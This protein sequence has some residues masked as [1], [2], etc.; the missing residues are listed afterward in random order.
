MVNLEIKFSALLRL[1]NTPPSRN[2][3]SNLQLIKSVLD[4]EHMRIAH[5]SC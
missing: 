5:M 1:L 4:G 3:T 2:N